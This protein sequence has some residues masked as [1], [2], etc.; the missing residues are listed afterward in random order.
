MPWRGKRL[1]NIARGNFPAAARALSRMETM[2]S[3]IF[4]ENT[5]QT[6]MEVA[7]RHFKR[8]WP[9]FLSNGA[10]LAH[11]ISSSGIPKNTSCRVYVMTEIINK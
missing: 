5:K 2:K 7:L 6:M 4:V 3:H 8:S 11:V 1:K 10:T 9:G